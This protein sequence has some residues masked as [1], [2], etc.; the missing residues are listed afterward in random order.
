MQADPSRR[1]TGVARPFT[2]S[3]RQFSGRRVARQAS[4]PGWVRCFVALLTVVGLTLGCGGGAPATDGTFRHVVA[5]LID[6]TPELFSPDVIH[7]FAITLED[8]FDRP[9][10]PEAWTLE[11][12]DVGRRFD[13]GSKDWLLESPGEIVL[14][15]QV[16][17][18][19]GDLDRFEVLMFGL[20]RETEVELSWAG[21]GQDFA[22]ERSVRTRARRHH[23][24]PSFRWELVHRE[25]WA[26]QIERLRL[27]FVPEVGRQAR[28]RRI[29]G[30]DRRTNTESFD[31]IFGRSWKLKLRSDTRTG[32]L[33]AKSRPFEAEIDVP[34][35]AVLEAAYGLHRLEGPTTQFAIEVVAGGESTQVF[36]GEAGGGG[37]NAPATWHPARIDLAPWAGQRITLRC[38]TDARETALAVWGEVKL[39][40]PQAAVAQQ[41]GTASLPT[42]DVLVLVIDTLRADRLSLYGYPHE[43]SPRLDAWAEERAVVFETAVT[44]APWTYPSHVSLFTGLD[45]LSHGFNAAN[46]LPASTEMLAEVL[47]AAGYETLGVTAG[48]FVSPRYGF[49]QGFDRYF[50]NTRGNSVPEGDLPV[51]IGKALEW[52]DA[53]DRPRFLFFHTFEVHSPY[54][55]RQPYYRELFG[56]DGDPEL[57]ASLERRRRQDGKVAGAVTREVWAI[58]EGHGLEPID[59][60]QYELVSRAY[61]SGIAYADDLLVD[62]FDQLEDR[63]R[64]TLVVITSDHGE[65]LGEQD[66]LSDHGYLYDFNL[67]VPMVVALPD[68]RGSGQ[69]VDRQVRL[70]DVFPTVLDSLGLDE[71]TAIDGRSMLPLVDDPRADFPRV[72]WS[73]TAAQGISMR[74]DGTMKFIANP[75]VYG[76]ERAPHALYDL[77]RDPQELEN[78]ANPTTVE[79]FSRALVE[80]YHRTLRGLL[81]AVDSPTDS[82]QRIEV[83]SPRGTMA[84]QQIRTFDAPGRAVRSTA[85]GQLDIEVSAG[86]RF[87][88]AVEAVGTDTP[89]TLRLE[90][91]A[92][93]T[94]RVADWLGDDPAIP[95]ILR[96]GSDCQPLPEDADGVFALTLLFQGSL[97]DLA[98][99]T[100]ELSP[101]LERQLRAL[102]YLD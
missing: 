91:A 77:V 2:S 55:A 58:D 80:R 94:I 72:A 40:A 67:L 102:G 99:P 43:T 101:E 68:G 76:R 30:T 20:D 19:A 83:R 1:T 11:G 70:V 53:G 62:F 79:P 92:P 3:P 39:L 74:R 66:G 41:E 38:T 63:G 51:N 87:S 89:F 31:T 50:T 29:W 44:T 60:E 98:G 65:A 21:P 86:D 23:Q 10:F 64:P 37:P 81:I 14:H 49:A 88:T 35:D 69:R 18:A 34:A 71:R 90:S 4:P 27:R 46:L 82:V 17:F 6:E 96:F 36:A 73:S 7:E 57:L 25:T 26:G 16:D 33:V 85:P 52:L 95:P 93:C 42:D 84:P 28:L 59:P 78:L 97:D 100:Q 13:A 54:H 12:D 32:R 8:R 22:P 48:G 45:T 47:Q 9:R 56:D 15:G 5:R 61:D 75:T 24:P